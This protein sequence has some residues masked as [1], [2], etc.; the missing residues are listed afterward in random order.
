MPLLFLLQPERNNHIELD[1]DTPKYLLNAIPRAMGI[2]SRTEVGPHQPKRLSLPTKEMSAS[3]VLTGPNTSGKKKLNPLP[4]LPPQ[5][6]V[7][8]KL[9]VLF[10]LFDRKILVHSNIRAV[11]CMQSAP[12]AQ[13]TVNQTETIALYK[14]I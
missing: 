2:F 1:I 13:G 12:R 3:S 6:T 10:D 4:S 9:T 11:L 8:S 14:S 7:V 5:T